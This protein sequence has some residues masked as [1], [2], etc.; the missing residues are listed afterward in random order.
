[1]TVQEL[2]NELEYSIKEL[3]F[4]PNATVLIDVMNNEGL[5]NQTSSV[6]VDNSSS[7]MDLLSINA[8]VE[9]DA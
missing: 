9:E 8:Y 1:M 6:L 5:E 3:G 4:N 2:I 7:C